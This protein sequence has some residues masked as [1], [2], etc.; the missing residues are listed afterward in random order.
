MITDYDYRQTARAHYLSI[1]R[2]RGDDLG[3]F[4]IEKA[5]LRTVWLYIF[6]SATATLAYGWALEYRTHLAVP[7]AM[8]FLTG[9]AVTGIFNV[10]NTLVVDLHSEQAVTASA[11]VS[12]TRCAAAAA[13]VSVL[14]LLFDAV[15][16]G[17]TFTI[18]AGL[19]YGIVPIL[20]LDRQKGW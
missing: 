9:L 8:H 3:K 16:P 17:W 15:G 11:S 14:Q 5:R 4:S 18:V 20:W 19:C 7:L 2:V 6:V 13:E 12:I 1:D 10:C